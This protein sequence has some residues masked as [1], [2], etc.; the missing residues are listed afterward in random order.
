M[1]LAAGVGRHPQVDVGGGEAG[2]EVV[3]EPGLGGRA[4]GIRDERGADGGVTGAEP[5]VQALGQLAPVGEVGVDDVLGAERVHP[6]TLP[7]P[8]DTPRPNF[9]ARCQKLHLR[10]TTVLVRT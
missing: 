10:P 5:R 7:P 1:P 6:G 8:T 3:A 4:H 2:L 9:P